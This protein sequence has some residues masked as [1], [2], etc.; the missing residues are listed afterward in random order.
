MKKSEIF[1]GIIKIPLDF[2]L[3]FSAFLAA[4]K[5][6]LI[7]DLIPG[8][9]IPADISQFP[10]WNE[11]I[12]FSLYSC[13]VLILIFAVNHMY[14]LK[15]TISISKEITKLFYLC[16]IWFAVILAYFFVIREIP[17]SR[18]VFGYSFAFSLI[19]L[20]TGRIIIRIIQIVLLK[21]GIGRRNVLIIGDNRLSTYI[22]DALKKE[23]SLRFVGILDSIKKSV[24]KGKLKIIGR[25]RDFKDI[26]KKRKVDEII[27]TKSNDKE[28]DPLKILHFCEQNQISYSFIPD[29]LQ[30]HIKN[31]DIK[32]VSDLPII[33]LKP[34]PLDGW[35]RVIKRGFDI[36][37]ATIGLVL[38]S[39]FLILIA[40][41]IK[42]DSKG[43][44]LFKYLDDGSPV[45]RV[46]QEG[47]LFRFYKFRT[48]KPNTHNLRYTKLAHLDIRKDSPMV[49][50]KKD[51]RVTKVG[52]FLRKFS[53]DELPQFWN[54]LKGDMSLV[55]PRPHFPEEVDNYKPYQKFVLTIK[56][57]ITGLAQISGRSD[58]NF[59]EEFQY[60]SSYIKNW[61]LWQDIKIIAKTP[62]VMKRDKED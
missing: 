40:I 15:N 42:I 36:L 56:P 62:F 46:G 61:S 24:K 45:K 29:L 43:N 25:I 41:A 60:D 21:K 30:L 52:K 31:I 39:P 50:I 22:Y 57:G 34:T 47:K 54:V 20:C 59:D 3:S 49:K 5:L 18:L 51:P 14:A 17:F 10:T 48:M 37:G 58:L 12:E 19:A 2:F 23:K 53:L 44:I 33:S 13:L 8:I 9:Q 28:L 7:T 11:Y 55:G 4:Y 1:L 35:Q 32:T 27:Q 38:F 26:A 6:R 16:M